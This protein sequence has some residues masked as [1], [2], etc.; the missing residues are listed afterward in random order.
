MSIAGSLLLALASCAVNDRGLVR[1]ERFESETTVLLRLTT[2]GAH[3]ITDFDDAGLTLGYSQRTY[4]FARGDVADNVSAEG[5]KDP[6]RW[7]ELGTLTPSSVDSRVG[8]P[9]LRTSNVSGVFFD[10]NATRIGFGI[11]VAERAALIV[12]NDEGMT[13]VVQ[14]RSAEGGMPSVIV[15]HKEETP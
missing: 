10:T 14:Y 5:V 8:P 12:P 7:V 11:G 4:A 13:V 2:L 6:A 1:V 9:I 3:L 15:Q